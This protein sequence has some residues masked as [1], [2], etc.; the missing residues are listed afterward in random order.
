MKQKRVIDWPGVRRRMQAST[1][2]LHDALHP[3]DE[4]IR[5]AFE[6]SAQ[7][8]AERTLEGA[9]SDD[10]LAVLVFRLGTDRYAVKL[11]EVAEVGPLRRYTRVP[12]GPSELF[13]VISHRGEIRSVI[14][15]GRLLGRESE[16]QIKHGFFV[17]VRTGAR[18]IRLRVDELDQVLDLRTAD[19]ISVKEADVR[20][21][22][23]FVTGL[24]RDGIAI[25]QADALF[26]ASR[27]LKVT[28]ERYGTAS[29]G[30]GDA[31]G[32]R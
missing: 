13:G 11:N 17:H 5:D 9:D 18:E 27:A 19:I 14:N 6:R 29:A 8:L 23:H 7:R 12:G 28:Q 1:E 16:Q 15:L 30:I 26:S 4:A 21:P 3:N 20:L 22:D 24:T 25:L 32:R 2:A 10:A 31:E